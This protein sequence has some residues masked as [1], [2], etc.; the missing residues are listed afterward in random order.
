MLSPCMKEEGT[1]SPACRDIVKGS[2]TSS[3][4]TRKGITLLGWSIS[5]SSTPQD[6]VVV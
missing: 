3:Q 5:S 6:L 1:W 4:E 2:I